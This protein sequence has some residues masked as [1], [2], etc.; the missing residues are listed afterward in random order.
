M[1]GTRVFADTSAER[2]VALGVAAKLYQA[3]FDES[4]PENLG[5][6]AG[7]FIATASAIHRFLVGP[8][9]LFL[10][11]GEIRKQGTLEPTGRTPGGST[12]QLR[13]N[14]EN[15]LSVLV[16]SAKGNEIVDQ[17]GAEDDL[18][19]TVE[20]GDGVVELVVSEDTR[21][22]TVR[23][24]DLGSAV[25]RV[26]VTD[27][28]FATVAVDVIAGEAAVVTI[29]EGTPRKQQPEGGEPDPEPTPEG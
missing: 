24:V 29:N 26:E 7:T 13:D 12:M 23:A 9:A 20:G 17:P 5:T 3:Q 15:D 14:E 8:A 28:L 22:A 27:E 25:V 19:W 18:R 6:L 16:A 4:K 11:I 1:A 10:T 2:A 21:T